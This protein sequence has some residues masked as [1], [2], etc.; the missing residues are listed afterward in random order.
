MGNQA[1]HDPR[2]QISLAQFRRELTLHR[3][4]TVHDSFL[5]VSDVIVLDLG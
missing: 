5:P 1:I 2:A 3:L 4:A